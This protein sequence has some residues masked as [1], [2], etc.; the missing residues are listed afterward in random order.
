MRCQQSHNSGFLFCCCHIVLLTVVGNRSSSQLP[1][2]IS[3]EYLI[4]FFL[5]CCQCGMSEFAFTGKGSERV[6]E[7]ELVLTITGL[8]S[9]LCKIKPPSFRLKKFFFK[10]PENIPAKRASF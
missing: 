1:A 2:E 4:F 7:K 3:K 9:V 5:S 8:S 6:L 10:N